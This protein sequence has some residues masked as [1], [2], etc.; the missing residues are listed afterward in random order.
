MASDAAVKVA[1]RLVRVEALSVC[2]ETYDSVM[3]GAVEVDC[4]TLGV[5]AVRS[6]IATALDAFAAAERERCANVC[7]KAA[8]EIR[9]QDEHDERGDGAVIF[10]A[11][12][13][14]GDGHA[15]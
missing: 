8:S 6:V 5:E 12:I 15:G 2:G 9:L 7:E 14:R 13:R 4:D 1:A 11:R 3:M 10:A